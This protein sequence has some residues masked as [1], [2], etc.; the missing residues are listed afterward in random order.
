MTCTVYVN[1]VALHDCYICQMVDLVEMYKIY[2]FGETRLFHTHLAH[3]ELE[4]GFTV[5]II[6]FF[7]FFI[8]V[9]KT[10]VSWIDC[11]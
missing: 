9:I 5:V 10:C 6:V 1:D 3:H 8:L 2:C 4:S 7:V 11:S